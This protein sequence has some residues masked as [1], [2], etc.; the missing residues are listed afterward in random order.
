MAQAQKLVHW[1]D[2]KKEFIDV[3]E[4]IILCGNCFNV[5]GKLHG[6]GILHTCCRCYSNS[7]W[8]YEMDKL[9]QLTRLPFHICIY[10]MC[11]AV[12]DIYKYGKIEQLRNITG[13]HNIK[14]S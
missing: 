2:W 9:S 12:E 5:H 4:S 6:G 1:F 3:E 10:L 14:E 8:G 11:K 7:N 13:Y